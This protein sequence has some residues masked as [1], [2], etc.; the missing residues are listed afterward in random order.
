M[1]GCIE[2]TLSETS[3][4]LCHCLLNNLVKPS[5]YYTSKTL[6]YINGDVTNEGH[7]SLFY[8]FDE[9]VQFEDV[10]N[11]DY[12]PIWVDVVRYDIWRK[13]D[14]DILVMIVDPRPIQ[15]LIDQIHERFKVAMPES[16][17]THITLAYLRKNS[18]RVAPDLLSVKQVKLSYLRFYP[19][20][21]DEGMNI[22]LPGVSV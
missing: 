13:D 5:D 10:Q 1:A 15:P 6:A 14:Y 22:D 7:I 2:V 17:R 20:G 19:D 3:K 9:S 4:A 12:Q 11:W 8:G 16:Y 21:E 18:L